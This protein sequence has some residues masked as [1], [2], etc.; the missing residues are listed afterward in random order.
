[1]SRERKVW[2]VYV[3]SGDEYDVGPVQVMIEQFGDGP[4]SIAFRRQT[5]D[6]WSRPYKGEVAP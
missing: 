6:T 1:M 4:P 5:R 3:N 2:I